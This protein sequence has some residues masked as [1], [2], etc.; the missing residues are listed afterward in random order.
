MLFTYN[1]RLLQKQDT[2]LY[3]QKRIFLSQCYFIKKVNLI[4]VKHKFKYI[5]KL[6]FKYYS[7]YLRTPL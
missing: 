4:K 3:S 7:V 6:K 1:L 5:Y 2:I